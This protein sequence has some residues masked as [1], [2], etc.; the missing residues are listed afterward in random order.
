MKLGAS[1]N[2][3][4]RP[5]GF[6][7]GAK[8]LH[9]TKE[10]SQTYAGSISAPSFSSSPLSPVSLLSFNPLAREGHCNV[11]EDDEART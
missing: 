10:F 1:A 2:T 9:V 7:R 11:E 5:S 4:H 8:F 3:A 6:L